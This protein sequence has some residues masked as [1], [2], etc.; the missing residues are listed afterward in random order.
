MKSFLDDIVDGAPAPLF[1]TH[2]NRAGKPV[3]RLSLRAIWPGVLGICGLLAFPRTHHKMPTLTHLSI[4]FWRYAMKIRMLGL[5]AVGLFLAADEAPN[6]AVKKDLAKLAGTWSVVSFTA[7]GEKMDSDQ[8]KQFSLIVEGEK[9]TY[10]QDDN[11]VMSGRTKLDPSKKPKAVDILPTEGNQAGE[12]LQ[13]IY[14]VSGDEY[15]I[16]FTSPEGKRPTEFASK[17]DSGVTYVVF[18]RVKK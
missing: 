7:N 12:K 3:K 10:K 18:K 6:P 2:S 11:V 5:L 8:T 17:A 1:H 4:Q 14:E 16:C 13:G 9:F 15:K